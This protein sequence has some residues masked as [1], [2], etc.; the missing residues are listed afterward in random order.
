MNNI[1]ITTTNSIEGSVIGKYL[2]IV[3]TN[4]VVGTNLFSDF[5]ASFTDFF[6]G[7]S[8]TYQR[9][10]QLIYRD[11]ISDLSSKALNIGA[12]CILGLHIDF[13]E[14]SGKN[15]S[16]FM[17][18]L[19]GT[20]VIIDNKKKEVI[21]NYPDTVSAEYLINECLKRKYLKKFVEENPSTEEWEYIL[22]H[23][24]PELANILYK[25]YIKSCAPFGTEAQKLTRQNFPIYFSKLEYG[26]AVQV[27]YADVESVP[28]E[29]FQ[30]I[31]DFNLFNAEVI[32]KLIHESKLE[33]AIWLLSTNKSTY[34]K[35]DLPSMKQI[36]EDFKKLPNKG[37]I[38]MI[39]GGLLSKDTQKYICPNGHKNSSDAEFC[40]ECHKNIKGLSL[41]ELSAITDFAEKVET[42]EQIF[43]SRQ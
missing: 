25:L 1:L 39:K 35:N 10:L 11:A 20:A 9:K 16:M 14:V 24:M 34:I 8:G 27:V 21:K 4:I 29:S 26:Q 18:S 3:S 23:D 13:D 22:S 32:S 43:A 5:A 37:A 19:V 42:L 40:E 28:K 36:L 33:I 6:G 2:G 12:N 38:E 17:V 41:K 15:K 30:L 31:K 7:Q